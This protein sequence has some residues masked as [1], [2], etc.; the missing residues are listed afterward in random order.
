MKKIK[1]TIYYLSIFMFLMSPVFYANSSHGRPGALVIL[2]VIF[3]LFLVV[4]FFLSYDLFLI[5][6]NKRLKKIENLLPLVCLITWFFFF[7]YSG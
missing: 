3:P 4:P 6:R 7:V 2:L 5:V 1:I